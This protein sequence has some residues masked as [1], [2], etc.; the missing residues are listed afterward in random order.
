MKTITKSDAIKTITT[1]YIDGALVES[2]GH[3]VMDIVQAN[4]RSSHRASHA[5]RRGRHAA[6]NRRSQARLRHFRHVE[7]GGS[8]GNSCVGCTRPLRSG[9]TI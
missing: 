7:T 4:R 5:R 3:E 9:L 8:R 6:R 2:H 1:H